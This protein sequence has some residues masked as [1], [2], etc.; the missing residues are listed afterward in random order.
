[1]SCQTLNSDLQ[2]GI[3][4]KKKMSKNAVVCHRCRLKF[5]K[6]ALMEMDMSRREMCNV[7]TS[8]DNSWA[9]IEILQVQED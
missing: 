5:H 8:C 4:E 9:L 1:M 2:A 6:P 3:K 7:F